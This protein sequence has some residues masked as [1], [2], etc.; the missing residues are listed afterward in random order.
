MPAQ[1]I[2]G[3]NDAEKPARY[4]V[5]VTPSDSTDLTRMSRGLFVGGAGNLSVVMAGDSA[6]VVFTGVPAGAFLPIRVHRVNA[7]TATN[8]VAVW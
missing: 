3:E 6:T 5:A 7:T 2:A 4:A 8:I 1:D